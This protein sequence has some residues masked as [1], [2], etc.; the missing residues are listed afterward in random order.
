MFKPCVLLGQKCG[1]TLGI[2]IWLYTVIFYT[3][4]I[5][6]INTTLTQTYK[7]FVRMVVHIKFL[8]NR[9]IDSRLSTISTHPTTNPTRLK[10]NEL[11]I[12]KGFGTTS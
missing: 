9:S 3:Q 10:F 4:N 1:K 2:N 7:L 11:V 12:N 6:S 8:L 5:V